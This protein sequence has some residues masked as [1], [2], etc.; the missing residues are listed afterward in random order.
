MSQLQLPCTLC[1]H[2]S[3]KGREE[4]E[5]R[6]MASFHQLPP[7]QCSNAVIQ[8][9]L[10]VEGRGEPRSRLDLIPVLLTSMSH[11]NQ[12]DSALTLASKYCGLPA[13]TKM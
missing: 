7:A 6:L 10:S 13:P 3:V 9:P 1:L 2:L 4:C 8:L 5:S 12:N 11:S